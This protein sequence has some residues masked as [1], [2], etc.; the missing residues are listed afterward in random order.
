[1]AYLN[2]VRVSLEQQKPLGWAILK[3]SLGHHCWEV[4]GVGFVAWIGTMAIQ[5]LGLP[6]PVILAISLVCFVLFNPWP[7]IIYQERTAGTMDILARAARWMTQNGPEWII[8][9][10]LVGALVW[11]VWS[12]EADSILK[13]SGGI[14]LH[15]WM[16]FRG[17]LYRH[18]NRG[19]RRSRAWRS[20][21]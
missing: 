18:L 8:P 4:I 1:M 7:E 12:H 14:L 19:S 10:L 13:L 5:W 17:A 6:G 15:P 3:D 21:F 11:G 20:Q 2:L 16:V 9:H